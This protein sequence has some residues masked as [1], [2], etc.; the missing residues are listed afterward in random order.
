MAPH[1]AAGILAQSE[2]VRAGAIAAA[3]PPDV[4]AAVLRRV[5]EEP[6]QAILGQLPAESAATLGAVMRFPEGTVGALMDPLVLALPE[7]LT[8]REAVARIRATPQ[9][10]RY[11]VYV[12]DRDTR[13]VGVLNLRELLLAK[14]RSLLSEVMRRDPQRLES[15]SSRMAI[16]EHRGWREVHSLPVVDAEGRYL[17]AVRYRTLRRLE[18][19]IR[20]KPVQEKDTGE[21]LGEVFAAGAAAFV[22]ALAGPARPRR[23]KR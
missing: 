16:V 1:H 17:G 15:R 7:D 2:P 8:A 13:L 20:G 12:V 22:D 4:A 5:P 14:P 11:N 3:L 19:E 6:R 18:A 21:A 9:H 10:A 23:E